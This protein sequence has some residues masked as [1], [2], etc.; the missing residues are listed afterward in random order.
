MDE[1]ESSASRVVISGEEASNSYRVASVN[2]NSTQ[3][4]GPTMTIEPQLSPIAASQPGTEVK[5]KRGRPRK[6]GPNGPTTSTLALS[7]MLISSDEFYFV[8]I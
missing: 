3:F 2:E 7:P 5:K 1:K 4:N 8:F 6:Y